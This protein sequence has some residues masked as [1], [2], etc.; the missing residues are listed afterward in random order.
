MSERLELSA[1]DLPMG[2]VDFGEEHEQ[3][4]HPAQRTAAA[5]RPG[6]A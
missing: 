5:A 3:R 4:D 1:H 6:L 2:G